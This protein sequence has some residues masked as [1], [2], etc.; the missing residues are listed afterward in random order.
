M[1]ERRKIFFPS[2]IVII[3]FVLL[4]TFGEKI[5]RERRIR[6]LERGPRRGPEGIPIRIEADIEEID[7]IFLFKIEKVTIRHVVPQTNGVSTPFG[8]NV[9]ENV[10][11]LDLFDPHNNGADT[12]KGATAIIVG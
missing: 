10:V 5:K 11:A 3:D 8:E 7:I 2:F 12:P 4:I 1:K 6:V 9:R